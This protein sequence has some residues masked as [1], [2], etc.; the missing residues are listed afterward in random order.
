MTDEQAQYFFGWFVQIDLFLLVVAA[1]WAFLLFRLGAR[2]SL[3]LTLGIA[4]LVLIATVLFAVVRRP[5]TEIPALGLVWGFVQMPV[6]FALLVVLP[7]LLAVTVVMVATHFL[8]RT[9]PPAAP[10]AA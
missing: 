6:F 7:C 5:Q 1:I 10:T 2:R 9:R 3:W 8:S 4:G